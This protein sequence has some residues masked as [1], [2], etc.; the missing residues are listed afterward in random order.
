MFAPLQH[1]EHDQ[2][3]ITGLNVRAVIGIFDEERCR[4]QD[5]KLHL[6]L[7]TDARAAAA[8]D[9]ISEALDYKSLTK[10]IIRFVES[11]EFFLIETL[12]ERVAQLVLS[13]FPVTRA[14][15]V[16][17]KPGALRYCDDVGIRVTRVRES[18]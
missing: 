11:S 2:I 12:A 5:L 17:Q 4:R 14:T 10:S 18:Q 16:I 9:S 1:H 13:E 7:D 3:H 15:V 6:L 8:T